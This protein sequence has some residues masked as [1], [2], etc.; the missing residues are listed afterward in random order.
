MGKAAISLVGILAAVVLVAPGGA[1]A[2]EAVTLVYT[3]S[4][5]GY[6][7]Y[8]H[9]KAE[10]NGGL[11]KRITE[12]ASIRG[13]HRNALFFDTGDAF[14]YD[15][16]PLGSKYIVRAMKLAGYDAMAPGDQEFASGADVFIGFAGELPFLCGNL[17]VQRGGRWIT[18]L[19]GMRIMEK[20]GV[21]MA[22]IGTISQDA[23]KF[24]PESVKRS[25]RVLDQVSNLKKSIREAEGKGAK[26]IVLLSHSGHERDLELAGAI[27][28]ID[29][30]IGG[31]SQTLTKQPVKVG[32]TL[33]VQ[34][35]S[36]GAHIGILELTADNGNVVTY[37]NSFRRPDEFRPADDPRVRRLIVE[38][39]EELKKSSDAPRFK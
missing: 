34:A 20:A 28:G 17:Q 2:R 31:H 39:R 12:F 37:K 32:D 26:F 4:L 23:F 6:L 22:V 27:R 30:I 35:G 3:N 11:V 33:V 14:T 29:V 18:P 1:L 21:K 38:Y 10:P 8:C 24:Y 9:C 25:V 16:D 13:A 15:P 19:P 36:N 5:N 7:D